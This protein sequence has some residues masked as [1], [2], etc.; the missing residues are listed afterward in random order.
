MFFWSEVLRVEVEKHQISII[1]P[2]ELGLELQLPMD[3]HG[4]TFQKLRG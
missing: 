2:Q 3:G 1:K 4:P